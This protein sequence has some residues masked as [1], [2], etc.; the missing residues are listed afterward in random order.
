MSSDA[1]VILQHNNIRPHVAKWV[2]TC[3]EKLKLEVLPHLPYSSDIALSD[4]HLF[5][6]MAEQHFHSYEDAKKWVSSWLAS[7]DMSFFQHGIQMLP[8]RWEKIVVSDGQY[9]QWHVSY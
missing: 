3:L 2:K 8:E 1:T 6:S 9:F 4:Y 5:W 7:K